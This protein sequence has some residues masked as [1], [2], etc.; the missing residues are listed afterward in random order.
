MKAIAIVSSVLY[1]LIIFFVSSNSLDL[2]KKSGWLYGMVSFLCGFAL[3]YGLNGKVIDSAI[4]GIG[5][6]FFILFNAMNERRHKREYE[7]DTKTLIKE[8]G[9]NKTFFG[10]LVKKISVFLR[11]D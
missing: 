6:V 2:R 1:V 5:F 11:K 9:E 10:R 3:V 7:R 8:Y 4:V